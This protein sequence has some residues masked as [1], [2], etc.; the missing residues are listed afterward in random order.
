MSQ[1]CSRMLHHVSLRWRMEHAV[2]RDREDG[3][4]AQLD[5]TSADYLGSLGASQSGPTPAG[6]TPSGSAKRRS[7]GEPGRASV[8]PYYAGYSAGFVAGVVSNLDLEPG[9]VILDPWN[10]SGTT[11]QVVSE[12]GLKAVGLDINPAMAIVAQARSVDS[13]LLP[14]LE[15]IIPHMGGVAEQVSAT[16]DR[17]P[18]ESWLEPTS[19]ASFR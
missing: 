17:D 8:F 6:R 1:A 13:A 12:Y 7:A 11:T 18:L 15:K 4:K 14:I 10:G 3:L 16:M 19:A 9:S 5:A 2:P